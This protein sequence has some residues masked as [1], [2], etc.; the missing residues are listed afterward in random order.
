MFRISDKSVGVVTSETREENPFYLGSVCACK[1][2]AEKGADGE[3][4]F[5]TPLLSCLVQRKVTGIFLLYM[6]RFFVG[7]RY[8]FLTYYVREEKSPR[9]CTNMPTP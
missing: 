6:L 7:F 5:L 8:D 4:V 9:L 3:P 1:L 2:S